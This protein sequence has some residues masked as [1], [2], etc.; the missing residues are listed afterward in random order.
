MHLNCKQIGKCGD[1][2]L[3]D[4]AA[5]VRSNYRAI[6]DEDEYRLRLFGNKV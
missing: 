2:V 6:K 1:M 5:V 3:S 4:E